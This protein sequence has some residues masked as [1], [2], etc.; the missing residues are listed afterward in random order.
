M[1]LDEAKA[2]RG[3]VR[4]WRC[5]LDSGIFRN[6]K[7]AHFWQYCLLKASHKRHSVVVGYEKIDLKP[8][9]FIFG[10]RKAAAETGLSERVIRTCMA[11]LKSAQKTTLETTRR[12]SVVTICNWGSYQGNGDGGVPSSDQQTTTY[13]NGKNVKREEAAARAPGNPAQE[14]GVPYEAILTAY[15]E[16]CPYGGMPRAIGL[17]DRRRAKLKA[18]WAEPV[19]RERFREIFTKA[20]ESSLCCGGGRRGWRANLGWLIKNDDNYVKVLEGNYDDG[21]RA[22]GDGPSGIKEDPPRNLTNAERRMLGIP[23]EEEDA[24]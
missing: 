4:T 24:A 5:L 15:N 18:R 8:G 17:T 19:F 6:P 10:R 21:P 20:A 9:Q 22:D 13:K 1:T 23:V 14:N 2:A 7:L 12:Y 11:A 3:Y 16:T